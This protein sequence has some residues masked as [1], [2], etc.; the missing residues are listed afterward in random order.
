MGK[1][2][3]ETINWSKIALIGGGIF[4]GIIGITIGIKQVAKF[5]KGKEGGKGAKEA[6]KQIDKVELSYNDAEYQA[7]A[8]NLF[9]LMKGIGT[10]YF[11]IKRIIEKLKTKSDWYKLVSVYGVRKSGD[12][13]GNLNQ[14]LIDELGT[15]PKI[16]LGFESEQNEISN[17]L[18]KIGIS[19]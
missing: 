12:F 14:W 8:D 1:I 19:F 2:D 10:D 6:E 17:I 16:S 5:I 11:P 13:T 7:M 18:A 9:M 3:L 4:A 15:I